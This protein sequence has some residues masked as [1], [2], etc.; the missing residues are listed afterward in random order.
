MTVLI[1]ALSPADATATLTLTLPF[2]LRAK[3]RLRCML[4]NGEEAGIVL[5]QGTVLRDGQKV[6]SSD[7]R[8]IEI[9]AAAEALHEV[10]TDDIQLLAR[11]AY[12]LGNRHVALEIGAGWLRLMRDHVLKT[13]LE[14]LGFEVREI[15]APFE[16]EAGAYGGGHHHHGEERGHGGH[17]HSFVRS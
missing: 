4:D 7:G 12:H 3:S 1:E 15:N 11:A 16:P 10:V 2:E 13:L 14:K 9:R 8:V 17:I 5:P 6:M